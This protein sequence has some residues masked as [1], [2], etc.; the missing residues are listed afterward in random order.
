MGPVWRPGQ[1]GLNVPQEGRGGMSTHPDTPRRGGL[2]DGGQHA[3]LT[4]MFTRWPGF[5]LAPVDATGSA[6][7]CWSPERRSRTLPSKTTFLPGKQLSLRSSCLVS[8]GPASLDSGW[9]NGL[10]NQP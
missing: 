10:D 2:P 5:I 3:G 1:R 8:L 4:E 6:P 7:P 9:I